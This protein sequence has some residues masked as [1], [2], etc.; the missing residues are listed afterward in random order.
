MKKIVC[1][2]CKGLGYVE[3]NDSKGSDEIQRCDSCM[4]YE[5]D[6]EAQKEFIKQLN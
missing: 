1:E 4:V 5:S 6:K 3:S 2:D